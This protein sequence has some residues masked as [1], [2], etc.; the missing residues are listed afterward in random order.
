[1]IS[2]IQNEILKQKYFTGSR[3]EG[4]PKLLNAF[5]SKLFLFQNYETL[6]VPPRA[7]FRQ[8]VLSYHDKTPPF[9]ITKVSYF[10]VLAVK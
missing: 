2:Q 3:F 8:N 4:T 5:F 6:E 1:M 9:L 7:D 10:G